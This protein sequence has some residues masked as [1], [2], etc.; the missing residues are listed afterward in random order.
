MYGEQPWGNV[1]GNTAIP[2]RSS[3][4]SVY[5]RVGR[6]EVGAIHGGYDNDHL[7][8]AGGVADDLHDLTDGI[9]TTDRCSPKFHDDTQNNVP[10]CFKF[11]PLVFLPYR[12]SLLL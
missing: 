4:G 2:F 8:F 1:G 6:A 3:I 12:L 9:S 11:A 7:M 5:Q 10:S